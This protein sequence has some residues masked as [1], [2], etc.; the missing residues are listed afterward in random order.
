MTSAPASFHVMAKPTGAACNLACDYCFYRKSED[1]YPGSRLRMSDAVMESYVEQ[2]IAG[3]RVPRVTL[4]WQ[5]GEP[6]LMGLDFF[7]RAV[8]VAKRSLPPGKILEW[9][10]QTNGVLVDDAWCEF[11]RRERFL[12][13]ISLDGPRELHDAYRR[14]SGGHSVFEKV[15]RGVRRLQAHGVDFNVLCTVNAGNAERPLEVYRFFRDELHASYLQFIPIVERTSEAPVGGAP[16][17]TERS[18]RPE[19]FGRFL[20]AIFDEWVRRDVGRMFVQLFDGVLASW[21][22]GRSSLCIFRPTCGD[23]V[24]LEHNGDLYSCD[25]FVKASHRLGNILETPLTELVA[26]EQQRAFGAA[27]LAALPRYCRECEFLFTCYGECPKNRALRT[28]DGEPGLNWLCA[29]LKAF[30]RH[31]ADQMK[32]MARLIQSGRP[33]AD[34][35]SL[36]GGA[37]AA[38]AITA[39]PNQPCPCGSGCKFK[40]CHGRTVERV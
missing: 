9:T 2:T 17:I 39:K 36:G 5:G 22:H 18:V 19:Q 30:F 4:A 1:L 11:L 14:D 37:G 33:A 20:I 3:Q 21:L 34:A 13:G 32:T 15:V 27:K 24:A 25:H 29:G 10:L 16:R 35:L 38:R 6:T 7:R 28:P 8:E 12:V 26:G 31:T 23:G 40:R